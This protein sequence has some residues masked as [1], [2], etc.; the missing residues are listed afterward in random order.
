M[1]TFKYAKQVNG[2][3]RLVMNVLNLKGKYQFLTYSQIVDLRNMFLVDSTEGGKNNLAYYNGRLNEFY[4]HTQQ[5]NQ[6][7]SKKPKNI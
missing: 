1:S 4:S 7:F 2:N 3:Y 5:P 6:E